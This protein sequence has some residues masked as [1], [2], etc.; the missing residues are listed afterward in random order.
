MSNTKSKTAQSATDQ[1]KP[2][3]QPPQRDERAAQNAQQAEAN[4]VPVSFE[5]DG[6]TYTLREHQPS[7]R[8]V[9]YIARWAV[10]DE[11]L[12]FIPA[13]VEML[14]RDQ[15]DDWCARHRSDQMLDFYGA[16]N[17]AIGGDEGN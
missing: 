4:G 6:Y 2:E 17:R 3:Q 15:W 8:A 7:P 10:D 5:F 1:E 12:A 14:G 13:M 16:L 11:Q 9:T